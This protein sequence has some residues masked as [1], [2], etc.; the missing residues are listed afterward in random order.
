[1]KFNKIFDSFPPPKFLS[2]PFAGIS[3]SDQAVRC[4]Q[5][6]KKGGKLS[7]EKYAER[8]IPPGVVISGQVNNK[9][10]LVNI[11]TN[12]RIDLKLDYVRVCISEEKA[13]LFTAKIPEVE[14]KEVV[15]AIES[16]IEENIPL[17]PSELL[18][19][20]QLFNHKEK[21]HVDVVVYALP[22]SVVNMYVD[23]LE[24]SGL[25][26]LS[27]EIESQ[28]MAKSLLPAS[29][30][31]TVLI[32][33]FQP[34]KVGL[35]VV[36]K[37][38]VRFTSTVSLNKDSSNYDGLLLQEIK[39][40]YV[41]WHT[42]KENIDESESKIDKIIICGESIDDNI[43]SYLSGHLENKVE[44]GNVWTNIFDLTTLI[45]EISFI[46]SLKYSSAIGLASS[47]ET[48]I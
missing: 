8:P 45:P 48:L 39:K 15:S 3:I 24:S 43:I 40:L 32:V 21:N 33:N 14:Q 31:E 18:F 38:V 41:Y 13:Y 42:L 26:P 7:I 36:K 22:I 30:S 27:L 5:F 29:D 6:S 23:I 11:L 2:I 9:D 10:E 37:R 46:D 17:E 20:Y 47:S 28:V 19:D 16:K 1:M 25:S 34:E 44:L 12:L 4:I 35:Y